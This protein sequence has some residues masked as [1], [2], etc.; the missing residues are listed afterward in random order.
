MR[1]GLA[2][3]LQTPILYIIDNQTGRMQQLDQP[4]HLQHLLQHPIPTHK[5]LR[6][7]HSHNQ[8]NLLTPRPQRIQIRL[9]QLLRVLITQLVQLTDNPHVLLRADSHEGVPDEL[10]HWSVGVL[11]PGELLAGA[12]V[13]AA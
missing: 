6:Y 8:P 5:H 2:P 11:R 1:A 3:P 4:P 7:N 10:L 13:P 12:E 9:Q